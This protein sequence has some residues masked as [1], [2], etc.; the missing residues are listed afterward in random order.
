MIQLDL[1]QG[2]LSNSRTPESVRAS[3][4]V[5]GGKLSPEKRIEIYRHNVVTTLTGALRDLY[6]V[7][8]KIVSAPFFLRL[9]ENFVRATPSSSGDLNTFGSEWPDFLRVHTDAINLPYLED[10][11]KL[12]WA[13]H[14]AFHAADCPAFD[15]ARLAKTASDEHAQLQF[16]LHPSVAFIESTHPIVRIWAVNQNEYAGDMIIDWTL[17]GDLALVSREDLTVKIQS[18]PRATFEFLQALNCGKTLG[19]AAD[20]AFAADAEFDL[21]Q[22]LISAIQSQLIID[23]KFPASKCEDIRINN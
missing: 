21:Q 22:A 6:A 4:L 9:A 15:L 20:I 10:V 18:L 19:A 16:S 17:P 1:A 23:F 11:A 5:K 3:G 12:E 2:L 7:T 14:R 8:E 13:W